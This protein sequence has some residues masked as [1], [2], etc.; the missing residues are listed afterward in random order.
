MSDSRESRIAGVIAGYLQAVERGEV[1]D[2]AALLKAHSALAAELAAY[3]SD[4]DRMNHLAD[5]LRLADSDATVPLEEGTPPLLVVRY[6]RDYELQGE[7]AR[8]GMVRLPCLVVDARE[9]NSHDELRAIMAKSYA[10]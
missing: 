5:P 4:L 8:G 9:R 2:R 10:R 1:P 6:F 7:I 3:F